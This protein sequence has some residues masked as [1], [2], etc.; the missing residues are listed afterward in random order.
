[1][2]HVNLCSYINVTGLIPYPVNATD[3][4]IALYILT[5]KFS[6]RRREDQNFLA[7]R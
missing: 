6:E 3:R 1:L 5:L 2:K 7:E 4:L